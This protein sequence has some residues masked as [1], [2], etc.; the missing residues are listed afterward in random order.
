MAEILKTMYQ[1]HQLSYQSGKVCKWSGECR[2]F[3]REILQCL[4]L[5]YSTDHWLNS[6]WKIFIYISEPNFR[7]YLWVSLLYY[8]SLFGQIGFRLT[9]HYLNVYWNVKLTELIHQHF[10]GKCSNR[11]EFRLSD[12]FLFPER[13]R[14]AIYLFFFLILCWQTQ[15]WLEIQEIWEK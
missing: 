2:I 1:P 15:S 3:K 4:Q 11:I 8:Y 7:I 10:N 12:I 6:K 9:W 5:T 14:S 13:I